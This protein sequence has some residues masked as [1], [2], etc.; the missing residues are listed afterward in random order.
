LRKAE[1]RAGECRLAAFRRIAAEE[2]QHILAAGVREED[3]GVIG[4]QSASVVEYQ[5][6]SEA[7]KLTGS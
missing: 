6:E 2:R 4:R 5:Y 3:G 1:L 7:V